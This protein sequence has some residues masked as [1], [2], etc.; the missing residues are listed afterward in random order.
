MLEPIHGRGVSHNPPNRFIPLNYEEDPA[1]VD[2]DGP[3]PATRFYHDHSR[4]IIAEN[5]SPDIHFTHS[6]N[7][8]RGCEHGC[9]YCYARPYHEY[10]GFSA[11][12]DFESKIMVK[13]DAP[14]L[15]RKELSSP[16]WE[17]DTIVLSGVTDCYQ[18]IERKLKITRGCLKV[19][20]EFRN[21]AGVVTKSRLVT[22]DIDL[23]GRLAEHQAAC[24]YLGITTLEAGLAEKLEPRATRPEGRLRAIEEL[25]RAGIPTGVLVA[26]V[27]PGLTEHEIP[28]ILEAA[29]QAGATLAGYTVL[30]LPFAVKDVFTQWLEQHVPEKKDKVLNRV[31]DMR[32]GKLNEPEFRKR[33]RGEGAWADLIS[34][35]FKLHRTRLGLA[36]RGPELSTA[37][38]RRPFPTQQSLFE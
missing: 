21:P 14:E 19:L 3:A 13:K 9:S 22:R 8:Y 27:I 36:P 2:P 12:L 23:L 29:V 28:G 1:S 35:M 24:V 15:L 34:N 5:D 38:F 20:A 33:M 6:L 32:G 37:A 31:R 16:K 10:L 4:T 17:P 25:V 11:G 26:P 18:P 30:R 7:P